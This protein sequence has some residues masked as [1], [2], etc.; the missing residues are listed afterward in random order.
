MCYI[1]FIRGKYNPSNIEYVKLLSNCSKTEVNNIK[2]LDF[3]ELWNKLW[4]HKDYVNSRIKNEYSTG[5]RLFNKLKETDKLKNVLEMINT[6]YDTP[7]WEPKG[8]RNKN[9]YNKQCA[10]RE[11]K[12]EPVNLVIISKL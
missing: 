10:I 4:I 11:F 5:K 9:E 2:T 8:R 3:D 1:E 7:E 6:Q 12:E